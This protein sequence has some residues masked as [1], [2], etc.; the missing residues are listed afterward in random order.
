MQL[1]KTPCTDLWFEGICVH[2][3]ARIHILTQS[4]LNILTKISQLS[5]WVLH[6]EFWFLLPIAS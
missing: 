2:A 1:R 6:C 4:L 5:I 3:R